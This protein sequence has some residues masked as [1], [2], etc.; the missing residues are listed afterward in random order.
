MKPIMYGNN[1]QD[2]LISVPCSCMDLDD[3]TTAY[4]YNTTY[5]VQHGDTS[6]QVSI[7]IYSGQAWK[8]K[9]NDSG[10]D[11]K[12]NLSI[13]LPF[14]CIESQSQT[15]VTYTVQDKDTLLCIA[16]LLSS[17]VTGIQ[18][19]NPEMVLNP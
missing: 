10:I 19:L 16:S 2:Y 7:E 9:A 3:N 4:F 14:G 11:A 6:D 13:S 17:D 15:V 8:G 1:I 12:T 5:P 18:S